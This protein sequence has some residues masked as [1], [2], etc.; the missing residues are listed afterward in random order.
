MASIIAFQAVGT[1]SNPVTRLNSD[2][3]KIAN[4]T[5]SICVNAIAVRGR[6]GM[7]CR[8]S[9]YY[10]RACTN[11]KSE[12]HT[13]CV[14]QY[15]KYELVSDDELSLL[16]YMQAWWNGLHGGLKIRTPRGLWVRIPPPVLST[17]QDNNCLVNPMY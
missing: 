10:S 1:G 2:G 6:K 13:Y 8:G 5:K 11:K 3:N 4:Q 9:R 17:T 15:K 12:E 7:N 16:K 14:V